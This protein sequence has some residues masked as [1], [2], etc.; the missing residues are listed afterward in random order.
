VRFFLGRAFASARKLMH[1]WQIPSGWGRGAFPLKVGSRQSIIV[2]AH[3]LPPPDF[4]MTFEVG[5]AF[6]CENTE[7]KLRMFSLQKRETPVLSVFS[8]LQPRVFGEIFIVKLPSNIHFYSLCYLPEPQSSGFNCG[9][10]LNVISCN[11]SV[12]MT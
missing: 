3:F 10:L 11:L 12:K 7:R 5:A 4:K 8:V 2:P 9:R 1:Q 6:A